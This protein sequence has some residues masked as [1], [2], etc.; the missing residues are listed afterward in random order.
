L[1]STDN[2]AA[3]VALGAGAGVAFGS[4]A[5]L[6]KLAYD[7]GAAALPLLTG[8]FVV[9][10]VVLVAFLVATGR[11]MGVPRLAAVRLLLL[12]AF[13]YA[14][15]AFLFFAALERAPAGV[16]GLIFYSYPLWTTLG[17]FALR[18]EPIT[19][20]TILAL[21]LGTGGV[22]S[23]FSVPDAST[24]GLWLA[25]GAAVAVAGYLTLAHLAM[26]GVDPYAGAVWTSIGASTSLVVATAISRS[27]VPT[28]AAVEL[29]AMGL[30][31]ALAYVFL[32]RALVLIGSAR[33]SIAMMLEPIA[34]LVLAAIFLDEDITLR[35]AVGAVL[36]V[37][38]LPMLSARRRKA[39]LVNV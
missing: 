3:G 6:A 10:S 22:I 9:A 39:A 12:G 13:G 25:L 30:I 31:T 14:F 2:Q 24:S 35:L 20:R 7:E 28:D 17:G 38:A 16:V 33:L 36:V 29:I 34:T 26:R 5:I 32:Y 19:S 37:S 18:L 11:T 8:R 23:V 4:V 1:T 27:A 15:E 21:V